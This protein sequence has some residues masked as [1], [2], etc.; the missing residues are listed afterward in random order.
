MTD[1]NCTHPS[2]PAF[3]APAAKPPLLP[4]SSTAPPHSSS[5]SSTPAGAAAAAAAAAAEAASLPSADAP[6]GLISRSLAGK[7]GPSICACAPEPHALRLQMQRQT[8]SK[9]KWAGL[10]D[11]WIFSC[12]TEVGATV[13][14]RGGGGYLAPRFTRLA[15]WFGNYFVR[16]NMCTI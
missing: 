11:G 13:N 2:P 9:K 6:E 16:K 5:H 15:P 1:S 10:S 3:P 4:S 7:Q 14:E 8:G 12:Y